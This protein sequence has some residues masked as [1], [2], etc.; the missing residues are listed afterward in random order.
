MQTDSDELIPDSKVC[1][2][3]NVTSM[4][5]WR[6]ERDARLNFPPK[7]KILTRNYRSRRAVNEFRER[8]VREGTRNASPVA[9]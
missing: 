3:F 5:L 4:T 8:M 9:A 1:R 2:E 6:W 7:V